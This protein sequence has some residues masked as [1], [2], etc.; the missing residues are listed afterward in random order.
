MLPIR[1]STPHLC[2]ALALLAA[3]WAPPAFAEDAP[4]GSPDYYPSAEQPYGFRGNGNGCFPGAEIVPRWSEGELT[5]KK[6]KVYGK[7]GRSEIDEVRD[8]KPGS[9]S[10]N[11]VWKT[12][13]PGWTNSGPCVVGDRVFMSCEPHQ[14]V[15]IDVTSGEILWTRA[16]SPFELAGMS[17]GEVEKLEAAMGLVDALRAIG[18]G[19]TGNYTRL[20]D[21]KEE[22]R[23]PW[24]QHATRM[25]KLAA[26]LAALG[27]VPGA[28]EVLATIDEAIVK[29]KARKPGEKCKDLANDFGKCT[30][31]LKPLARE[32]G[33][34]LISGWRSKIGWSFAT[35]ISD[36]EHVYTTYGQ[37]QAVC[38]DLEGNRV[39]GRFV[40]ADQRGVGARA[41]HVPSPLLIGDLFVGQMKDKLVAFDKRTGRTVW[42]AEGVT[43]GGG[44][45]V[46]TAKHLRIP[47]SDGDGSVDVVVTTH[48]TVLN[49]TDG[50]ELL[51]FADNSM[52]QEGGGPSVVG[53]G[54]R[55]CYEVKKKGEKDRYTH[56]ELGVASGKLEAEAICVFDDG[57]LSGRAPVYTGPY[58]L[59]NQVWDTTTGKRVAKLDEPDSFGS[60]P[61]CLAG[62]YY[63]AFDRVGK[64][65]RER[66]DRRIVVEATVVDLAD[67]TAPKL[68][69]RNYLGGENK[70]RDPYLERW[71][72]E[73]YAEGARTFYGMA[74]L[75][76]GFGIGSPVAMANRL[77]VP[78]CSHLYC[79]GDP[80][81]PYSWKSSSR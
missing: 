7:R 49:A 11:I 18:G 57:A 33:L 31:A 35:P 26:Q 12:Q 44:Y 66:E 61:A 5:K 81:Q 51:R 71:L 56:F 60:M 65:R 37:G 58:L 72:P 55:F 76:V 52:S 6:V 8:F 39:W 43:P 21:F 2:I 78:S 24:L 74:T 15:C 42:E 46:G 69:A 63:V 59:K 67:P 64:Y 25:R 30:D 41:A 9:P 48:G 20:P 75:P 22:Y 40:P 10:T 32:A 62:R 14:L 47:D 27:G 4:F 50:K 53:L 17:S 54:Q 3:T 79:I 36:G 28:D 45:N 68:V 1:P 73:E 19:L 80:Q 29:I 16:N 34:P 70:P 38:Y 13:L 23:E 77:F